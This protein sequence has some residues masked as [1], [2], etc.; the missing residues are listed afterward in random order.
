MPI[1]GAVNGCRAFS[2]MICAKLREAGVPAAPAQQ[3][4]TLFDAAMIRV[5]DAI[6]EIIAVQ[7]AQMPSM[8]SKYSEETLSTAN[9]SGHPSPVRNHGGTEDDVRLHLSFAQQAA[10][11]SALESLRLSGHMTVRLAT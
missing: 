11:S 5:V 1:N 6:L 9:F 4:A 7:A 8:A 2:D 10:T 3:V